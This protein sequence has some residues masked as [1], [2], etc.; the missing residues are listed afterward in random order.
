MKLEL[1]EN[2]EIVSFLKYGG[3][4]DINFMEFDG[5]IPDDFEK[6]FKPNFYMLKDESIIDNPNY[7]GPEPPVISPSEQDKIN[8]QIMLNQAKQ[9]EDQDKFNAQI[10][11][12]LAGGMK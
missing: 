9:K 11:L 8:A 2:N 10:L 5:V 12:K 6:N 1:N 7:V 3:V 4:E